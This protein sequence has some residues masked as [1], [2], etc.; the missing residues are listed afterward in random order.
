MDASDI[1]GISQS[2]SVNWR[3]AEDMLCAETVDG[4]VFAV[5]DATYTDSM[6][7]SVKADT[8][9]RSNKRLY[10]HTSAFPPNEKTDPPDTESFTRAFINT[11]TDLVKT[12]G[13]RPFSTTQIN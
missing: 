10:E 3:R 7:E 8:H 1:K 12:R 4:D 5:L 2:A 13:S 11:L 6:F 9:I